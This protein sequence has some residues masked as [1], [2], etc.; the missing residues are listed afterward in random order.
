MYRRLAASA[1]LDLDVIFLA[2]AEPDRPWTIEEEL[3]GV[4]H[5]FLAGVAPTIRSRRNTFVYEINPGIVPLLERERFDVLVIGGYAVFA[6]QAA[7]L[8]ARARRVPYLLHS[9]SH[10]G[11]PRPGWR[12]RVKARVLPAVVGGA[13]AG[14]A[15]GTLAA[16]YLEH[17]G[18]PSERIRIVPNTIDVAGYA[19]AATDAIE[20]RDEVRARRG[21][22]Q[23]YL[24]YAGRLV[25]SKGIE[26]LLAAL[27]RRGAERLP[28]VVAGDGPLRDAVRARDNVIPVGFQERDRLIELF[29]LAEATV[30]PSLDEPWGVVVNEALACGSPVV[31][32][33]AVGAGPDLIRE[34]EDGRIVDAGDV[35][36]LA[37]ALDDLPPRHEP[38]TGPI[39]SWTYDFAEAQCREA[40]EIALAR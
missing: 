27:D 7:I 17:Y 25:E 5:R 15:V 4:P 10:L 26:V 35:D 8:W 16:A 22:P 13:N 31:A 40:I 1:D 23:R 11:K 6:E 33:D 12:T 39:A 28:L 19:R 3:D 20:R 37:A 29:A 36:A 32:S 14:L 9:E 18:L 24:L 30:V 34:G 2:R 21:L 38:G